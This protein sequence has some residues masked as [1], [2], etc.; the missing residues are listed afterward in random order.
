[1]NQRE[2]TRCEQALREAK[3]ELLAREPAKAEPARRDDS[4]TGI[5]EDEQP[6]IEM[7]QTIASRRNRDDAL[8]LGKIERALARLE[9]AP[10]DFGTCRTC[11][12]E[13]DPKRMQVAPWVDACVA[14]QEKLDGPRNQRRHHAGDFDD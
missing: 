3:R 14:C 6:L 10:D 11:E 4:R 1:M 2:R 12:E 8:K 13:I 5:D 7:E 9:A